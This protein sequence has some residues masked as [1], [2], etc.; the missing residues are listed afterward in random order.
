MRLR[1]GGVLV[2]AVAADDLAVLQR[3]EVHGHLLE[4][5]LQVEAFTVL[6][7]GLDVL[8]EPIQQVLVLFRQGVQDAVHAFLHEGGLVQLHLIRGELPDLVGEGAQRLLEELVDGGD[9][10]GRIVVQDAAQ[11]TLSA[12]AERFRRG[13]ER[14]DEVFVIVRRR[15]I[16]RQDVQFLQNAALHL[17]GGLVGEGHGED[18]PIGLRILLHEEQA[19]V[20]TGQ[21]VGLPRTGRSFQNPDHLPQIILKSQ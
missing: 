16:R 11:L 20:F 4:R 19:D 6:E 17:V 9:G 1:V 2:D 15:R 18:V 7:A 3:L 10:K 8:S 12:V 21:V 13:E 5:R 14:R